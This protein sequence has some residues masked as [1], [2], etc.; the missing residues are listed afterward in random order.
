[1][2]VGVTGVS[3]VDGVPSFSLGVGVFLLGVPSTG[4]TCSGVLGASSIGKYSSA[5]FLFPALILSVTQSGV[6]IFRRSRRCIAHSYFLCR[7]E[8]LIGNESD[9]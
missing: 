9:I 2:T 1:M 7:K 4:F 6:T 3:R 5:S 8:N